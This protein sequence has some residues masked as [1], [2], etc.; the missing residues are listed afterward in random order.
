MHQVLGSLAGILAR[1]PQGMRSAILRIGDDPALEEQLLRR[2][3]VFY[4]RSSDLRFIGDQAAV[5]GVYA[6]RLE[7]AQQRCLGRGRGHQMAGNQFEIAR[8]DPPAVTCK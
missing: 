7:P 1:E 5:P 3:Y 2:R 4:V 8:D 6:L